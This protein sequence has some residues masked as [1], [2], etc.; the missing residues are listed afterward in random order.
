MIYTCIIDS[1]FSK[2]LGLTSYSTRLEEILLA[3]LRQQQSDRDKVRVSNFYVRTRHRRTYIA[4]IIIVK[5]MKFICINLTLQMND[6]NRKIEEEKTEREKANNS[7]SDR[8][9]TE[10]R[11]REEVN[12]AVTDA[13]QVDFSIR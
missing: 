11:D 5:K 7:L 13:L 2:I 12:E 9:A 10:V 4:V 1:H 8:I 3:L 6:L